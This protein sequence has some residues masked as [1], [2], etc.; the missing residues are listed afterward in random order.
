MMFVKKQRF[1]LFSWY[2]YK[3]S[4]TA[5]LNFLIPNSIAAD[6]GTY[7]YMKICICCLWCQKCWLKKFKNAHPSIYLQT[8]TAQRLSDNIVIYDTSSC[9]R[10][11]PNTIYFNAEQYIIIT[12]TRT[13]AL[14]ILRNQFRCINM[15][16][17]QAH[18][19]IFTPHPRS[20]VL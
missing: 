8:K 5:W 17:I 16:K 20:W 12:S 6:Y 2:A 11:Y 3:F 19:T 9:S 13:C 1:R 14:R 18:K 4:K 10:S 7:I 15:Y